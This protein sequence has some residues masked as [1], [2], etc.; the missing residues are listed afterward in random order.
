ML[1]LRSVFDYVCLYLCSFVLLLKVEIFSRNWS[2]NHSP[3]VLG[4]LVLSLS[5]CPSLSYLLTRVFVF[6]CGF[7]HL[8]HLNIIDY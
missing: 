4:S 5:G 1:N 2:K 6:V 8:H 3:A 7:I